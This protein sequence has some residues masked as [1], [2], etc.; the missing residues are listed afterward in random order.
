MSEM[1]S[2]LLPVALW[3][4]A[5][6]NVYVAVSLV[7]MNR[8][9]A[10]RLA[11]RDDAVVHHAV[12]H[13]NLIERDLGNLGDRVRR[14]EDKPSG[15]FLLKQLHVSWE[16]EAAVQRSLE[17]MQAQFRA[18]GLVDGDRELTD[19]AID[20]GPRDLDARIDWLHGA[21]GER[22]LLT[23]AQPISDENR[24]L[25]SNLVGTNE[26]P[27]ACDAH[28]TNI[29][30]GQVP[31][32]EPSLHC[33]LDGP[34]RHASASRTRQSLLRVSSSFERIVRSSMSRLRRKLGSSRLDCGE[35][36]RCERQCHASP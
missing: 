4:V 30:A 31:Q 22:Q 11:L 2:Y 19:T 25:S 24:V 26:S 8:A 33:R 17:R 34:Q 29:N 35:H 9:R 5:L 1:P 10:R 6:G 32:P 15:D 21:I 36:R 7:R 16:Y 23:Q 27:D 28:V 13:A 14:L 12:Q 20:V 3:I 18:L